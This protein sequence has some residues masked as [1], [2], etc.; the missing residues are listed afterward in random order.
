[1]QPEVIRAI[2]NAI[3][4]DYQGHFKTQ[5][6]G[7]QGHFEMQSEVIRAILNAIRGDYQGHFK[8]Q[9]EVITAIDAEGGSL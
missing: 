9:S 8:M 5:I 7:D 2:L 6:R 1:M 4:G 3:Q